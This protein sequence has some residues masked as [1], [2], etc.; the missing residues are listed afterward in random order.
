MPTASNY[1][2]PRVYES[3]TYPGLMY[4]ELDRALYKAGMEWGYRFR[5][6]PLDTTGSQ[7]LYGVHRKG[8]ECPFCGR[9]PNDAAQ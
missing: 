2:E 1:A 8:D 6:W 5:T 3:P 7:P 9:R 4:C